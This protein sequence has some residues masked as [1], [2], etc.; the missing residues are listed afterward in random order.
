MKK[1]F[2]VGS[3]I[4]FAALFWF[5]RLPYS[6]GKKLTGYIIA[7]LEE[8][9]GNVVVKMNN[10]RHNFIISDGIKLGID[11]KRFQTK[12]IGKKSEL[13]VTHPKWPFDNTPHINK[14]VAEDEIVYTK[15]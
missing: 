13:W 4:G 11:V 7:I 2:L 15:W 9:D 1:S 3:V 10:D 6:Y 8:D 5:F 12:L 14:L